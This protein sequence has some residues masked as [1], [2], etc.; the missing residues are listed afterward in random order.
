MTEIEEVFLAHRPLFCDSCDGKMEYIGGGEYRCQSCGNEQ[1]DDYGKIRVYLEQ[2]PGDSAV[3][4]SKGTGVDLEIIGMFL[5]DGRIS[6][7]DNSRIFIKCGRCGCALRHGRY[8]M[9]CTR[10]L[11]NDI[12][13]ALYESVGEKPRSGGISKR[14][15]KMWYRKKEEK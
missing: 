14:A 6:I 12:K 11:A 4:I 7:P 3:G 8:C 13:S 10:E 2:N 1:L 5:K 15:E 9:D